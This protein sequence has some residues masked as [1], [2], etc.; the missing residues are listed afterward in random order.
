M[1]YSQ[2]DKDRIF[3]E[4]CE[5]IESGLS[6][7]KATE[8]HG[9]ISNKVFYEWMDKDATKEKSKQYARAKEAMAHTKFDSIEADYMEEPQRD[10]ETGRIDTGW[11]QLQRLKI[12]AKKW[13]LSKLFPKLYG[14]KLD[15]TSDGDKI[16][17]P[18]VVNVF[19]TAPPMASSEAEIEE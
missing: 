11:V 15:V 18:P 14:D 19:N 6:L 13:E 16:T 17:A 8:K 1:A 12:D 3:T 7:R 5:L 9:T 4:I 2:K 10:R